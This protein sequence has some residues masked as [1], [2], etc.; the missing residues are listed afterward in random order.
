MSGISCT[1]RRPFI[2]A[3]IIAGCLRLSPAA[4]AQSEAEDRVVANKL[5]AEVRSQGWIVYSSRKDTG[6]WDLFLMR[7]DGSAQRNLTRTETYNEGGVRFSPDGRQLLFYRMPL[8]T[9][10]D[11][12]KYGLYDLV[13]ANADG[14]QAVVWGSQYPW[15]CWGPDG[16]QVACLLPG[17]IRIV[18]V[19]TRR[20]IRKL[21]RRGIVQQLG[22]SRDGRWFTGTANGLGVAWCVGALNAETTQIQAVTE[23]DR[24]N[25]TPDWWPDGLSIIYSRGIVPE[26]KGRAQLWQGFTDGR[27]P[28][29]LVAEGERHLYGGY[30]SPD[31]RYILFTRSQKDLGEVDIAQTT[32][33][34]C[35]VQDTPILIGPGDCDGMRQRYPEA[36]SGPVLHLPRGWE[37]DWT[38][39]EID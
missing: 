16:E 28:R 5:A 18:D 15:A 2:L 11:N 10:M 1:T 23:T 30:V 38:Y 19:E 17:G 35:R 32:M 13:L 9:A 36:R 39:A 20:E 26:A 31:G 8:D 24:Y 33:A 37:P 4:L 22:W 6:D 21:P 27:R 3:L 7:P 29:L 25:C 14:S 12:N 34:I